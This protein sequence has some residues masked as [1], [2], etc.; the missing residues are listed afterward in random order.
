MLPVHLYLILLLEEYPAATIAEATAIVD[1]IL[2]YHNN[3]NNGP[4]KNTISFV[5]DDE[6]NNL[7]LQDAEL[8]AASANQVEPALQTEKIY[9]DAFKQESFAGGQRY[10]GVNQAIQNNFSNGT[11]IWNFSGHGGFRRLTEEVILDQDIINQLKNEGKLP[12]FVTA[13]CDVAPFD[14]PLISSIGEN[15]LLRPKYRPLLHKY[16]E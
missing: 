6:D 10:P 8:I 4:W 14:N 9:L 3:S 16:L 7:H 2:A 13:T 5:A 15:L 1:K 12:L 11:L